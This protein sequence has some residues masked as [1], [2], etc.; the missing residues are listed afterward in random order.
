MRYIT[1]RP[2]KYGLALAASIFLAAGI[3]SAVIATKHTDIVGITVSLTVAAMFFGGIAL[4]MW[5]K[6]VSWENTTGLE[7]IAYVV[8]GIVSGVFGTEML[9]FLGTG[10]FE[11]QD[12][13]EFAFMFGVILV[14]AAALF[15]LTALLLRRN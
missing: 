2:N 5:T 3:V 14:L 10:H 9:Y 4:C 1:S 15:F 6:D 7:P 8:P 12:G 11:S 13:R